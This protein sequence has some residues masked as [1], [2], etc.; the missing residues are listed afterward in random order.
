MLRNWIKL[1]RY[2]DFDLQHRRFSWCDKISWQYFKSAPIS[3][4]FFFLHGIRHIAEAIQ[5]Q[6]SKW[7]S[8]MKHRVTTCC[9]YYP[10][11]AN[12][13][14]IAI[15]SG[16]RDHYKDTHV[17]TLSMRVYATTATSMTMDECCMPEY[18]FACV[19]NDGLAWCMR[20]LLSSHTSFTRILVI[21]QKKR[22]CMFW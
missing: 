3:M 18:W 9:V 8:N 7:N 22:V 2:Y 20:I 4:C 6:C 12:S 1:L 11:E 21:A 19:H 15:A 16:V 14:C 5:I 10:R 17:C 13:D